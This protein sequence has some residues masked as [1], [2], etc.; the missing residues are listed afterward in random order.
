MLLVLVL[1][2]RYRWAGTIPASLQC[3]AFLPACCTACLSLLPPL[4]ITI[5]TDSS[6]TTDYKPVIERTE[7]DPAP[8]T[9]C[10]EDQWFALV[11]TECTSSRTRDKCCDKLKHILNYVRTPGNMDSMKQRQAMSATM[12]SVHLHW[13]DL[14]AH[15][16]P[17]AAVCNYELMPRELLPRLGPRTEPV[18]DMFPFLSQETLD[19]LEA[20]R[21]AR[22]CANKPTKLAQQQ[23]KVVSARLKAYAESGAGSLAEAIMHNDCWWQQQVAHEVVKT[24]QGVKRARKQLVAAVAEYESADSDS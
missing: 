17:T 20:M 13:R 6:L 8:P 22:R 18:P 12:H 19:D 10:Q 4:S 1:R 23:W 5:I 7:D 9:P 15:N 16:H 24:K 14:G 2:C 21:Q 11:T 3:Y